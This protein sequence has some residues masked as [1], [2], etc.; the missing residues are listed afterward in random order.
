M[1]WYKFQNNKESAAG[2]SKRLSKTSSTEGAQIKSASSKEAAKDWKNQD[3]YFDGELDE[4]QRYKLDPYHVTI[5]QTETR[6]KIAANIRVKHASLGPVIW[7]HYLTFDKEDHAECRRVMKSWVKIV[8]DTM[9]RFVEEEIP[10]SVF[11]PTIRRSIAD[12]E[13]RDNTIKTNIPHINFSYDLKPAADW[14]ETI[15]G[16]RYPAY[17]EESFDQTYGGR[18]GK[19]T[20]Q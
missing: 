11:I 2:L 5:V 19:Q 18:V 4:V 13:N 16:P 12:T 7:T 1:N 9:T 10:T 8:K 3:I 14:R 20:G 17:D 6:K 15:Y